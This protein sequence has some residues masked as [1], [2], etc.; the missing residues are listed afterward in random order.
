MFWTVAAADDAAV[1][2]VSCFCVK[3]KREFSCVVSFVFMFMMMTP[4]IIC[5]EEMNW[6]W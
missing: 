5:Y 6:M 1:V 2:V 3:C 4:S